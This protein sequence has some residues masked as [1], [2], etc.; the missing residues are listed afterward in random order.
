MEVDGKEG[1]GDLGNDRPLRPKNPDGSWNI[2]PGSGPQ[3]PQAPVP[4]PAPPT[5]EPVTDRRDLL[6]PDK[7]EVIDLPDKWGAPPSAPS[8]FIDLPDRRSPLQDVHDLVQNTSP[9]EAAKVLKVSRELNADPQYVANNLADSEKVSRM[10]SGSFLQ[11]LETQSPGISKWLQTPD[12]MAVAQDDLPHLSKLESIVQAGKDVIDF[13]K[14]ALEAGGLQE[15]LAFMGSHDLHAGL[16][17]DAIPEFRTGKWITEHTVGPNAKPEDIEKRLAEIEKEKPGWSNPLKKGLY[18]FTEFLPMLAGNVGYAAEF[19][20][21]PA[22]AASATGIGAPVAP[23]ILAGAGAVGAGFY[24]YQYMAGAQYNALKKVRDANGNPLPDD[25]I[26]P[27]AIVTGAAAAGLSFV[28]LDAILRTFPA[29]R[30]FLA[31]FAGAATEKALVEPATKMAALKAFAQNTLHSAAEGSAAMVG[32]TLA[33]QVGSEIGKEIS[34]QPFPRLT[35]AEAEKEL[36]TSAAEGYLTFGTMGGILGT[37]P[38]GKSLVEVKKAEQLRDVYTAMGEHAE[39]S[40]VRERLPE[41]FRSVVDELT[42]DGP[43]ENVHIPVEAFDTYFQSKS[44]DPPSVAGEL[45]VADSYAEAKATGGNVQVPLSTYAEKLVGT[46]H[47][48]GLA[49]DVKFSSEDLTVRESKARQAE[50]KAELQAKIDEQEKG[51]S[52][53]ENV[54]DQVRGAGRPKKEANYAG[55][56]MQEF[57]KAQ[58]SK[59]G[60]TKTPEE[61]FGKIPYFVKGEGGGTPEGQSFEQGLHVGNTSPLGFF[62]Q[63]EREVEKMDFNSIPAKDLA[64]RIKNIPGIKAEE[65]DFMGLHEWLDARGEGQFVVKTAEGQVFGHRTFETKEAAQEFLN[66]IGKGD[67][68][69]EP[70][71]KV[72]KEE[73]LNFIRNNGVQVEQKVLAKDFK[74][75][76]STAGVA[77]LS[78]SEPEH[79]GTMDNDAFHDEYNYYRKEDTDGL[80]QQEE[81]LRAELTSEYTHDGVVD[82][83]GLEKAIE[84]GLDAWAEK[85]AE[86]SINNPDGLYAKHRVT[87]EA[88]D[89]HIEGN[90]DYGWYSDATNEHYDNLEEAKIQTALHLMRSGD[91][92]GD[93]NQL[94]QE[95]DIEW[96]QG[97]GNLPSSKTLKTKI[98]ALIRKDKARL[99]GIAREKWPNEYEPDKERSPEQTARLHADNLEMVAREEVENAYHDTSNKRNK[100]TFS[101]NHSLLDGNITGNDVKGY[102]LTVYGE[103]T[104]ER[105]GRQS[106]AKPFDEFDLPAKTSDAAKAQAIQLMKDKGI[107]GKPPEKMTDIADVN[108]PTGKAK[109]G[110]YALPGDKNYRE[111]LLTLP[112]SGI[113]SGAGGGVFRGGHFAEPNVLAHVRLT[114]RT[115]AEGRKT[116]FIEEMQSDWHQQGRE[117]GYKGEQGQAL[118]FGDWAKKFHPELSKAD[119][120]EQFAQAR[121]KEYQEWSAYEDEASSASR[122]AVPDA[123]FKSTDAWV[124]LALKR[125]LRMAVEQGYDAVAWTPSEVQVE[126][127]GTERVGWQKISESWAVVDGEGAG[128]PIARDGKTIRFPT[129]KEAKLFLSMGTG[130]RRELFGNEYQVKHEPAHYLVGSVRQQGGEAGGVNIEAAARERGLQ[131]ERSGAHVTTKEELQAVIADTLGE[132]RNSRQ[133]ESLAESTWE[134]MQTQDSGVREPRAEGM[135]FFYDN[136]LPKKVAPK[137]LTKLDKKAKVEVGSFENKLTTGLHDEGSV[138]ESQ[139]IWSIPITPEMKKKLEEGLALFQKPP[140]EGEGPRAK[141]S[142]LPTGEALVN[143]FKNAADPSSIFHEN[144][145]YFLEVMKHLALESD[146]PEAI[147]KQWTEVRDW[148]GVADDN[149]I[150]PEQHERFAKTF[151]VYLHT[152]EAPSLTLRRVFEKLRAWMTNIY[153]NI[154]GELGVE[155]TPEVKAIF[156]RMLATEDAINEAKATAG[157]EVGPIEGLSPEV[158]RRVLELQDQAHAQAENTLLRRQ[159]EELK[160]KNEP[161]LQAE[162]ERLTK[163]AEKEI[164]AQPVYQA[165]E[166][167][168]AAKL[169]KVAEKAHLFLEDR[170]NDKTVAKF[171]ALAELHGFASGEEL[172]RKIVEVDTQ[173][174]IDAEVK[175][176]VDAGM[177]QH[178][179]M[180]D[181]DTLRVEALK[182]IHDEKMTELLALEKQALEGLIKNA[183]IR[184]EA[185]RRNRVEAKMEADIAQQHARTILEA[186]GI[187]DV[188]ARR[189]VTAERNAAMKV[190]KAIAKKDFEGAAKAKEQQML[191]HALAREAMR[192]GEE[193]DKHVKY[194]QGNRA[195]L[196]KMPYG[197]ARQV[198]K[199]LGKFGLAEQRPEDVR[200][201]Q[202]IATRMTEQGETAS[203][204]ADATGFI[205]DDSGKWKQ[206]DFQDFVKRINDDYVGLQ[207]PDALLDSVDRSYREL[208]ISEL[209]DLREAVQSVSQAGDKADRY[210]EAFRKSDIKAEAARTKESIESKIG[211][212]YGGN[213][214]IGSEF[215]SKW[216]EKWEN[217]KRVTDIFI[218]EMVNMLTLAK[219]LDANEKLGPVT[220]NVY[221]PMAEAENR[222]LSRLNDAKVAVNDIFSKYYTPKEIADY[223]NRREFV[224]E[225]GR[226]MNREE[227]LVMALNWGNEGNRERIRKGYNLDDK[228]IWNI[229][230]RLEK[231]DWDFAHDIGRYLDTYFPDIAKLEM[232][233]RGIETK[234]VEPAEVA[235]KF[236]KYEGWYFPI[237]YDFEKSSAAYTNEAM[238]NELYK[239]APAAAAQTERGHAISRVQNVRRPVRLSMGV[240]FNHLE[241]VIHDLEFRRAV[242][243]V[244]RYLRQPEVKSSIE[245]AVGLSGYRAVETWLKSIA[246]D[247]G[248]VLSPAEKTMRWFRFGTTLSMIGFRPQILALK[249]GADAISAARELGPAKT[250]SMLTKYA[251]EG[252]GLRNAETTDFVRSKSELMLHRSTFRERD[253]ADMA[254]KWQGQGGWKQYA[255]WMEYAADKA[256]SFPLWKEIY[257]RNVGEFGDKKA[258]QMADEAVTFRLGSGS[259]LDRVGAQRGSE[260]KKF[261]SMYYTFHS[262][263]FNQ[264]WLD[265]KIAGL[266]YRQGNTGKALAI[267][268]HATVYG[269]VLPAIH[270]NLVRETVRN[271][272]GNDPNEDDRTKRIAKRTLELPFNNIWLARDIVPLVIDQAQGKRSEGIHFSPVEQALS[273]VLKPVGE[274]AK[275]LFGDSGKEFDQKVAEDYARSASVLVGAPQTINTMAFNY[276]DW[277]QDGEA[278]WRDFISRRVKK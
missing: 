9:E 167:F 25:I 83:A 220:E 67:E 70:A 31:R 129:E 186:K 20:V 269:W 205:Q 109:Y 106:T 241:N 104:N 32:I 103:G 193:A 266:E 227:M 146:A 259:P 135:Q 61:L 124:G 151:E 122:T 214:G 2:P 254:K 265:G 260:F 56:L 270:E 87:E 223:K 159:M 248:E 185:S 154:K 3:V 210:L 166:E 234:R 191:N 158:Q 89:T 169:G 271:T 136:L 73:V 172:A 128:K 13:H 78:W 225:V 19:G 253:L 76:E 215:N 47:Y 161:F 39:N 201:M 230:N 148:L 250:A 147:T 182:A 107:I 226:T 53:R 203:A 236:G 36:L 192:I 239:T 41:A 71:P 232:D 101:I 10:P 139:K 204:I 130:G 110:Q 117:K 202:E 276:L 142:F 138:T 90:D 252:M 42:K 52:I 97:S 177:T 267:I 242:I 156:D 275:I 183:E 238:K 96:R 274:T 257:Q 65:L 17:L 246:S 28:K 88:T 258:S 33:N 77:D 60:G 4:E 113:D 212:P 115:D 277:L 59:Y 50:L 163:E 30:A 199:M 157:M 221:R 153:R 262:A 249:L 11:E 116:L 211:S 112:P 86:D 141:I 187:K 240:L 133:V 231:R 27:T 184:T 219:Y 164:S 273:D 12:N 209:R 108:T 79:I 189:Y 213:R 68:T 178:S 82:E 85:S 58:A 152:G 173:G 102:T 40:K 134:R 91:I 26:K 114:D 95:K 150:T 261:T 268:A 44:I 69:I 140:G 243:D 29:G 131:L 119:I 143:L 49:D 38:L 175:A 14:R 137:I 162:R 207:L 206:E 245:N 8:D 174:G 222:K 105:P 165:M 126:R 179:A 190:A 46:E 35:D 48:Q 55:M 176:R 84:K 228:Q 92:E 237:A 145:H 208:T 272:G 6:S 75:D 81:E 181:T 251:F 180:M 111:V 18:G 121:G 247:Q 168:R 229:L 57:F 63:V 21:V 255:F 233:V 149:K 218:P 16:G 7:P 196:T 224:P 170:V 144:S 72:S 200:T 23:F 256:V 74:G 120:E 216:R 98:A 197:F 64:S 244:N 194:L 93:R 37:L 99:E 100:V 188:N 80:K 54:A 132:D 1:T 15:Q 217:T 195:D 155:L 62:S 24:N 123:P 198:R 34:G 235:T 43:I 94:I 264:A 51:T 5:A 263:M 125:M 171:E 127:W 66:E 22:A 278:S 160:A 45:G 118:N